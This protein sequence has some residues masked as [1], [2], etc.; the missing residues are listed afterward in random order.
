MRF[1]V[2]IGLLL[3]WCTTGARAETEGAIAGRV[4]DAAGKP[5]ASVSVDLSERG[6]VLRGHRLRGQAYTA[7][8]GTFRLQHLPF[9]TYIVETSD[10]AE[11]HPDTAMAFYSN[12]KNPVVTVSPVVPNQEMTVIRDP[13][14]G[15]L[16]ASDVFDAVTGAP[17]QATVK[18][19]RLD[20][21]YWMSTSSTFKSILVPPDTGVAVEVSAPGYATWYYPGSADGSRSGAISLQPGQK[22]MISVALRSAS[23]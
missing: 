3:I 6:K 23:K 2:S 14:A 10:E 5:V 8:D 19:R 16:D 11:G 7:A 4:V 20:S 21:G 9:G 18:L 15:I 17:V 22:M 1:A 12:L 13:K